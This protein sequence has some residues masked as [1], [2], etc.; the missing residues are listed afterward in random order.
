MKRKFLMTMVLVMAVLLSA[1]NRHS[2]ISYTFNVE[3]NVLV[4]V[5][6]DTSE[7][8]KLEQNN[9]TFT[10]KSKDGEV[11]AEGLFLLDDRVNELFDG[12]N[13]A[14]DVTVISQ[15]TKEGASDIFYS[16]VSADRQEWD[17]IYRGDGQTI[18]VAFSSIVSQEAAEKVMSLLTFEYE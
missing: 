2:S 6:L 7:G 3:G 1:C 14:E 15:N 18:G 4:K 11:L 8:H 16:F 5:T 13:D 17:Y 12:L 9:G 10:V